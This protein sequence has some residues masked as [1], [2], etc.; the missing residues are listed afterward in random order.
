MFYLCKK[1]KNSFKVDNF[2]NRN[3]WISPPT[4]LG[5]SSYFCPKWPSFHMPAGKMSDQCIMHYMNM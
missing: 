4:L 2:P 5:K 1:K 3:L